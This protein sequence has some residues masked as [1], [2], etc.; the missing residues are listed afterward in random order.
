MKR[1][2]FIIYLL[3]GLNTFLN[4]QETAKK[5]QA[6]RTDK[7]P[8]IDGIPNDAV[9]NKADVAKDFVMYEPG[10]GTPEPENYKTFV[11]VLYD[12]A[13]LYILAEMKD[14]NPK[15]IAREFGLR[16]QMVQADYFTVMINPFFAPGETKLFGV[17]A[18][19]A[20]VDGIQKQQTDWTWNAVWKSAVSFA[21]D[22]WYV[23]IAIPYS[24]LRFQNDKIQNWGINFNRFIVKRKEGYSWAF[25]DKT[26]SGDIVQFLGTLEGLKDLKP[27]V[28]LSLYPYTSL[29][30]TRYN[31]ENTTN[32][33]YGMDLKYGLNE[34]FTLDATLIPDFSDTPYDNIELNLGPFEQHYAEKRQF[35]TEGVNLFTKGRLF[36]SRRIGGQ[37]TDYNLV[38][39]ELQPH[40][41]VTENP[42]NIKLINAVKITG[43]TQK[44][45]GIG[46]LNAI[47]NKTEATLKD[48]ITGNTRQILTEPYTNYNVFVID[49]SFN[50]ASSIGFINTSVIRQGHYRDANVSGI[51]YNLLFNHN[52]L[53]IGGTTAMSLINENENYNK[54]FKYIV[55]A[56]KKIK[57]H[58]FRML[59]RIYDDKFDVNDL[60]YLRRNNLANFDFGYSYSILKPTKHFNNFHISFDVGFDHLYKPFTKVQRD[61]EIN[62]F[63]T[64][65]KFLSY[66]G[67]L[68]Y[69]TDQYDYYEPRVPG[70]YYINGAYGGGFAFL[71]TDY[72]KKLSIDL[73]LSRFHKIT[74]NQG[75]FGWSIS[76]RVRLSNHMKVNYS[77][78]YKQMNNFKGFVNIDNNGDIIFG[79]RMQKVITQN[80]GGSYYFT[81]KSGLNLNFRYYWSPVHYN[82]FYL[83]KQDGTLG[84]TGYTGNHDINF[85][86][87]NL[88]LS[89]IWEFAPGSQLTLLYRNAIANVDDMSLLNYKD[90]INNL[91]EQPQKNSFIMKLTY[92]VDYNVVKSRWF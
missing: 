12:D 82:K 40:E 42:E 1:N 90:N 50:K 7:A 45:L 22:A 89:Y 39:G 19:G 21:N 83:L 36:Y 74:G 11:K 24:N 47:T 78:D 65:K 35:F 54:G 46:F 59:T 15:S 79:N 38:Y 85:N 61:F 34:S 86:V 2:Y 70:R 3:L 84:N 17:T 55:Y 64:N 49:Y 60:G 81:T 23:E 87:W 44:G 31:G 71:S 56:S 41:T 62:V 18:A 58:K 6:V 72:R 77:F 75:F 27:P 14:P 13:A 43:R 52:T 10:N 80:L 88:D 53:N 73:K 4:A 57:E 51:N 25:L 28:R 48:T 8:K 91:F 30:Y 92:Y 20:Q 26:K 9:W 76:P 32:F 63:A 37:P 67:G 29:V 69:T 66:G 68:E 33:G 16:D 5:I